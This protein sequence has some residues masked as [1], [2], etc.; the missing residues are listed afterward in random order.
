MIANARYVHT[1]LVARDWRSLAQFYQEILGC[2]PIPPER[3]YSGTDLEKGTNIPGANLK[4]AHLCLPGYGPIGPTLEIFQYSELAEEGVKA[5]NRPGFG[6]IAF[7]VDDVREARDEVL[8]HGGAPVGE[9]VTLNPAPGKSV[10]WCYV[11]DPEGNII[12]LQS[13]A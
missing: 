10:T 3:D 11:R 4:G 5:V 8:S 2:I 1:N 7:A 12:E 13:W 9:V 6:H